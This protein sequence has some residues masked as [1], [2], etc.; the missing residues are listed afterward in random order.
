M[1]RITDGWTNTCA[2]PTR[3][4]LL[5]IGGLSMLGGLAMSG[6]VQAEAQ[7]P[8]HLRPGR[9]KSVIFL[10]L[11]GGP[12]HIDMFDLKPNAPEEIRGEFQPIATSVP[13]LQICEHLPETAQWM[14]KATL[15][16]SVTHHYN[17]HN[18]YAVLTGFTGGDDREN[19]FT[20][21][22]DHP[23]IGAV[24]QAV[25]MEP[26]DMPC[27]VYLPAHPGYSQGLRR[28]GPYG[29]YLGGRC[30]P[31]FTVCDPTFDREFDQNKEF[32]HPIAPQGAPK[33]PSLDELP[34][35]SLERLHS[36]RTLLEQVEQATARLESAANQTGNNLGYFRRKALALLTS[37]RARS[38]F[39]LDREPKEV[40]ERY[41]P[42]LFGSSLLIARR[43]VE[44]GV[45]FIGV[46]T[47]SR[48]G[49]HW[50][51]HENNFGM[52]KSFNLPNLDRIGSALVTDLDQRG[53]LD[54]TLVVIMGEMGRAPRVNRAAGRDH[55]PQCGF[56]LLVGGGV[57]QGFVLGASDKT[58]AYPT[59]HPVSPGD[60]VATI[61]QL[62][63]VDP[64]LTIPDLTGRPISIAHG[65]RPISQIIA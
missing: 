18:P 59:D 60:L 56:A 47:E 57:K 65:G 5:R 15:I 4:E 41:G 44:A 29:G 20:K 42:S 54:S 32:Y 49:G 14:H 53:L 21:R 19:Y 51:A 33:L 28:A 6:R 43:L 25:G 31:L 48:G 45:P 9:A 1:L 64:E 22:S 8:G 50:D 46:T 2:G 35:V 24:C 36:R 27:H 11:F 62:L 37:D 16:R 55:W 58:A 63:G 26:L 13:G 52:L 61:Y 23:G 7:F 40:K 38:A 3:R 17:S 12:S 39:D 30:D 34:D 10:S